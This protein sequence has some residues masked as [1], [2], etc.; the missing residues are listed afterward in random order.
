MVVTTQQSVTPY[1]DQE[2]RRIQRSFLNFLNGLVFFNCRILH[3]ELN[4][5]LDSLMRADKLS[6]I[7]LWWHCKRLNETLSASIIRTSPSSA[8]L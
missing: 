2:G 5:R 6:M 1:E 8:A 3:L 7:G 4:C